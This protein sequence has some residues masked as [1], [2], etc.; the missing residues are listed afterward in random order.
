LPKKLPM[1]IAYRMMIGTLDTKT[2]IVDEGNLGFNFCTGDA[3]DCIFKE[4]CPC[5][6]F[7][8]DGPNE[9]KIFDPGEEEL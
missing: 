9:D 7:W 1:P 4:F 6:E 8:N 2:Q 3:P 5:L